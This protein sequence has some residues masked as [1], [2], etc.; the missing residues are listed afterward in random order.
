MGDTMLETLSIITLVLALLPLGG[1]IY[2]YNTVRVDGSKWRRR[3]VPLW[4]TS[5]V[6]WSLM[7]M[8]TSLFLILGYLL[9]VRFIGD[10]P[11]RMVVSFVLF[12]YVMASF[13]SVLAGMIVTQR[14]GDKN[15]RPDV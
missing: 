14:A 15:E 4:A 6:G 8:V 12:V 5:F 10:F 7:S 11:G 1:I 2:R 3:F 13:W 9:A